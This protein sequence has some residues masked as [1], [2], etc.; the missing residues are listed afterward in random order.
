MITAFIV[1]ALVLAGS[2]DRFLNLQIALIITMQLCMCLF[3]SIAS[4]I[5]RKQ[6]GVHRYYLAMDVYVQVSELLT[7]QQ[8]QLRA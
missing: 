7:I 6:S 3:C 8:C 1:Y 4:Y 2:Y 5:W